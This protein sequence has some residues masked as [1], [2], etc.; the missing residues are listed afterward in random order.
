MVFGFISVFVIAIAVCQAVLFKGKNPRKASIVVG[1]AMGVLSWAVFAAGLG[2]R[3]VFRYFTLGDY[4][5]LV[6]VSVPVTIL[7]C[8]AFGYVA[9]WFIAAVFLVRKEP[10]DAPPTQADDGQQP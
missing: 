3:G 1:I 7:I 6:L 9:G 5:L 4:A 2:W 10:D 8:T